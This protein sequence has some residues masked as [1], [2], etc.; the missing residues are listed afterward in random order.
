MK[1]SIDKSLHEKLRFFSSARFAPWHKG[2]DVSL[3]ANDANDF[4]PD[5]I[6]ALELEFSCF[7]GENSYDAEW[8]FIIGGVLVIEM[9]EGELFCSWIGAGRYRKKVAVAFEIR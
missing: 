7:F 9:S 5:E 8:R 2:V 1:L 4:T 3:C 6:K